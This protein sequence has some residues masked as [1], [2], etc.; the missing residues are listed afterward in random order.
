MRLGVQVKPNARASRV[1]G[2]IADPPTV[3]VAVAAPPVDGKAN[4]ELTRFLAE[5]LGI[6]KSAVVIEHGAGGRNKRVQL[7][8]GTSLAALGAG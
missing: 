4:A 5:T 2:W 8:D 7:P 1:V 6:P 3:I